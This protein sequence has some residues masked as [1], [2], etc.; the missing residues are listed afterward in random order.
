MLCVKID[1]SVNKI[2]FLVIKLFSIVVIK[3]ILYST[4][5]KIIIMSM[6]YSFDTSA[7]SAAD[8]AQKAELVLIIYFLEG[9]LVNV[10]ILMLPTHVPERNTVLKHE[11]V[12]YKNEVSFNFEFL[13]M[14]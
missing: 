10:A 2:A 9:S 7:V 8:H 6:Q 1:Y 14:L 12:L 11:Y 13:G 5:H 3:Q 4:N